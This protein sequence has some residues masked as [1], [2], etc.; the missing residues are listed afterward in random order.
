MKTT[1]N[2]SVDW[3]M[4]PNS[5]GFKDPVNGNVSKRKPKAVSAPYSMAPSNNGYPIYSNAVYQQ[6]LLSNNGMNTTATSMNPAAQMSSTNGN[7]NSLSGRSK[8][9]SKGVTKPKQQRGRKPKNTTATVITTDIAVDGNYNSP[10]TPMESPLGPGPASATAATMSDKLVKKP[11]TRKKRAKKNTTIG[12]NAN[13]IKEP[14]SAKAAVSAAANSGVNGNIE[15]MD[16]FAEATFLTTKPYSQHAGNTVVPQNM[17]DAM[18]APFDVSMSATSNNN[19]NNN[20]VTTNSNTAG[21]NTT[22][23]VGGNESSSGNTHFVQ[24]TNNIDHKNDIVESLMN[25]DDFG[26]NFLPM[27]AKRHGDEDN[28]NT[29]NNNDNNNNNNT[30]DI[31]M[32]MNIDEHMKA[33][34]HDH[35]G[36][37]EDMLLKSFLLDDD[38]FAGLDFNLD[39]QNTD[40]NN[41]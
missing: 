38:N 2:S 23:T 41:S 24:K 32:H 28:N 25:G 1:S 27:P 8:S 14:L 11:V 30:N 15:F 20:N 33:G 22:N 21:G 16:H 9:V 29:N 36:V 35:T 39:H 19:N 4:G 37:E 3:G 5:D 17:S 13:M 7:T 6:S 34:V 26:L 31:G 40:I 18:N 12:N 10:Y